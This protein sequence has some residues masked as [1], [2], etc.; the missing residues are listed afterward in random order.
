MRRDADKMRDGGPTLFT[1]V[2]NNVGVE[3]V[4]ELIL[5]AWKGATGGR[6]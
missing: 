2:R 6:K 1:S 4:A 5:G 3:G